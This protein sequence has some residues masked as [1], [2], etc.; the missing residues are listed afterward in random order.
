MDY[1]NTNKSDG[2]SETN[3]S[4]LDR[5][6]GFEIT[7]RGIGLCGF[8]AT[9]NISDIGCGS[10][11][12]MH[13]LSEKY[14]Y[15]IVGVDIDPARVSENSSCEIRI[16]DGA[17]LPF[18]DASLDGMIF[19][20]SMSK[21]EQRDAVLNECS[22]VLKPGGKLMVS[23]LYARGEEA[24]LQGR[25]GRIDRKETILSVAAIFGFDLVCFEDWSDSL[26]N[27]WANLLF[28]HGS[29]VLYEELGAGAETLKRVQCGYFLAVFAKS[30]GNVSRVDR[31]TASITET[32][33]IESLED[34]RKW[35]L[36]QILK[37]I[38]LAKSSRFYNKHFAGII[39]EQAH[40]FNEFECLPFTDA[41]H[42]LSDPARFLAISPSNVKR[43]V[44]QNTTGTTGEAKRIFFT[45]N[46]IRRTEDFFTYALSDYVRSG[47]TAAVFMS[48]GTQDGI[49]DLLRRAFSR[50]NVET[51]TIGGIADFGAAAESVMG[52]RIIV[53]LPAEMLR[54]CRMFPGLSPKI[55]LL[56]ADYIPESVVNTLKKTWGCKVIRHFGMTETCFGCAVD[57]VCGGSQHIRHGDFYIEIIDPESGKTIPFGEYG[58]IVITT[59]RSEAYPLIRYRT[60]DIGCLEIGKCSCGGILPR[61][62]KVLGRL[63]NLRHNVNIHSLDELIFAYEGVL[64]FEAKLS[65]GNLELHIDGGEVDG[66]AITQALNVQTS[67]KYQALGAM[68]GKRKLS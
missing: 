16:A 43:I 25:L 14:G 21:M 37:S 6:G 5:P 2:S 11:A 26:V 8:N 51:K 48:G 18:I 46:D 13:Y 41:R 29:D 7:E 57:C 27:M 36:S 30:G 4:I 35:Q 52:C 64:G 23:D 61:L 65:D 28:Q 60:G 24:L 20:C 49:G 19:E 9:D 31:W 67:I 58:E 38:D 47:D 66:D 50:I 68:T 59:L 12:T 62:G 54:L 56:S 3:W 55:V 33:E 53:G 63:E 45:E 17:K 42:L 1:V 22:R 39:R 44:T 15:H 10:G 34:M 32:G 40:G